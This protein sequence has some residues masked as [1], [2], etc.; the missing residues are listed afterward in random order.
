MIMTNRLLITLTLLLAFAAPALAQTSIT[1]TTLS[2]AM[3]VPTP[4]RQTIAVASA[5]GITA[6]STFLYIDGGV[7]Q[8]NVVSGLNITVT[9]TQRPM[10]HLTSARVYVVPIAAQI[11]LD[12]VG[13]CI[14]GTGGTFPAYSPY[15]LMFNTSNGNIWWC[16]GAAGSRTWRGANPYSVGWPSGDPPQTP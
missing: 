14:R 10:T 13:S 2:D 1:T 3:T 4:G 6:N 8:V 7:Y 5:T 11:G 16:G 15:T 9:N 12:P